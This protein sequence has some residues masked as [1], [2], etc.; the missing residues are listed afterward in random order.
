MQYKFT[1]DVMVDGKPYQ[2]GH[3][4]D[5]S[6][7]PAGC[8]ASCLYVGSCEMVDEAAPQAAAEAAADRADE[9]GSADAIKGKSKSKNT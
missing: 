8:L 6:Q 2:G 1:R 4:Y 7:I 5:A 9:R 3:V